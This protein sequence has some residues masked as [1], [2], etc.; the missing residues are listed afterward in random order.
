[1]TRYLILCKTPTEIILAIEGMDGNWR[2]GWASEKRSFSFKYGYFGVSIAS[3]WG[4][5]IQL[6]MHITIHMYIHMRMYLYIIYNFLPKIYHQSSE[7]LSL[8]GNLS[9]SKDLGKGM[10]VSAPPLTH[11]PVKQSLHQQRWHGRLLGWDSSV[12]LMLQKSSC[13]LKDVYVCIYTHILWTS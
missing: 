12:V 1:M 6:Y 9:I 13:T 2:N 10:R 11:S 8:L 4:V 5:C 7:K 3:I